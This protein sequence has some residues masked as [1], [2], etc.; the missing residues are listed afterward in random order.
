V[1]DLF[2]VPLALEVVLVDVLEKP[3]FEIINLLQPITRLQNLVSLEFLLILPQVD[4][5]VNKKLFSIQ[6]LLG[7]DFVDPL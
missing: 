6:I 4:I 5:L 2:V 3:P 7:T 1:S